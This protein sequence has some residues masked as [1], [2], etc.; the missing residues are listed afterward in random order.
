MID[1]KLE[2]L[3][4]QSVSQTLQEN[5]LLVVY[6]IMLHLFDFID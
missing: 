3:L 2:E 5:N 1:K 4:K 6:I